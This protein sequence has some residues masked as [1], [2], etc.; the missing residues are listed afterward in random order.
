MQKCLKAVVMIFPEFHRRFP[1]FTIH[2]RHGLR[3]GLEWHCLGLPCPNAPDMQ[4]PV[5]VKNLPESNHPQENGG[6]MKCPHGKAGLF[7]VV[8]PCACFGAWGHVRHLAN[9]CL[10]TPTTSPDSAFKHWVLKEFSC[11][12]SRLN[13]AM[14]VDVKVCLRIR[15][16]CLRI[17]HLYDEFNTLFTEVE[18]NLIQICVSHPQ[19][20]HIYILHSMRNAH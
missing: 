9:H 6:E 14:Y 19:T 16:L 8:G 11:Q 3:G 12:V 18:S 7:P 2:L 10:T 15:H 5:R 1:H 17:R 4:P 13:P 20:F